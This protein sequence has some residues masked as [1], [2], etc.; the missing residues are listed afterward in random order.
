MKWSLSLRAGADALGPENELL[1]QNRQAGN[2]L[3]LGRV[4][5]VPPG[6]GSGR[7]QPGSAMWSEAEGG[8]GRRL[9]CR[10]P[11]HMM[12]QRERLP[13]AS[14][15]SGGGARRPGRAGPAPAVGAAAAAAAAVRRARRIWSAPIGSSR[16][17]GV[18]TDSTVPRGTRPRLRKSRETAVRDLATTTGVPFP[19][20][21]VPGGSQSGRGRRRRVLEFAHPLPKPHNPTGPGGSRDP[22]SRSWRSSSWSWRSSAAEAGGEKATVAYR[23]WSQVRV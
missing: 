16:P 21:Q 7:W 8:R 5:Y 13:S 1:K 17:R 3:C 10:P 19:Q 11:S 20:R 14:C 22:C 9:C 23:E 15:A 6:S 2:S 4:H 18:W 12:E